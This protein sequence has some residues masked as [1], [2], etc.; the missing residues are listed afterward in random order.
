MP[1]TL[2]AKLK[3]ATTPH[4]FAALRA[5]QLAYRNGL[6]L[7]SQYAFAHGKT[8]SRRRLQRALYPEVRGQCGLP[9]QM[10]CSVFRQVGAT[11]QGLWTKARKNAEA[12]RKAYT[13]KRF[14][15]LD[16][17]PHYVSPTLSYVHGRDYSLGTG[18]QVSL[19]T[20][21]GRIRV[22][23][24]GYAKHVALL[25][26]GAC[27]GG[28]KLWYDRSKKRFY[29][30]VAFQIETST[31][32][33]EVLRTVVGVDVGQRYLATIA[34]TT[35]TAQFSGGKEI[36][37]QADHYARLQKRLQQKGTRSATRRRIAL[38]QRERRLKLNTNHCISKSIV[39]RHSYSFI[40][41]EDL[42]HIRDR[43]RRRK[44]RRK[45]KQLVL[46]SAKTKKA[47]RHASQWAFAELQHLLVYK[48]AQAGS[49]CVKVDADYTSQACLR[50]GFTSKANRK[51]AGLLFVCRQCHYR[52]HADLV[53]ARNILLRALVTRQDWVATG[54]LS[55]APDVTD[56]EAKAARLS[57]YAELRWSLVTSSSPF[58]GVSL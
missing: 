55:V 43:T 49:V 34:T 23:Y 47:N 15:G 9:A 48:A 21:A 16:Q 44:Y 56:R 20:L 5:T 19:L 46:V 22:T 6:N 11:Y 32:P 8:G 33:S 17:A 58:R 14:R 28:A 42:T 18:Q 2:T 27:I 50:C 57:R 53:G 1:T 52:L 25:Q 37:Q 54:Q 12:L 29:L 26:R 39:E 10:A 38:A 35:G 51:D 3:L 13:K 31:P 4:Q 24:R 45:G 7:V 40:G 36:R 30:L 41:L